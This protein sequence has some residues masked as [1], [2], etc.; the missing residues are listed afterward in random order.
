MRKNILILLLMFLTPVFCQSAQITLNEVVDDSL[1]PTLTMG[2]KDFRLT[3]FENWVRQGLMNSELYGWGNHALAGYESLIG[4]PSVTGY[5]PSRSTAGVWTWVALSGGGD[6]LGVNNLSDLVSAEIARTNLD[7]YGKTDAFAFNMKGDH[8]NLLFDD[9][10]PFNTVVIGGGSGY[11]SQPTYSDEPC[12]TGTFS[13]HTTLG[14][15]HCKDADT[16]DYQVVSG[17]DLV[18]AV[19]DN[20][21]PATT[22]TA[23]DDFNRADSATLGALSGGTYTW[24]DGTGD[25]QIYSNTATG[26]ADQMDV[27]IL[28]P[29]VSINAGTFTANVNAGLSPWGYAGV[30]FGYVDSD[31]YWRAM[32]SPTDPTKRVEVIQVV[33]G[34]DNSIASAASAISVNVDY[35][36]TV[37]VTA[38]TVQVDIDGVGTN[39]LDIT[40]LTIPLGNVGMAS[41]STVSY[42]G[43]LD[44]FNFTVN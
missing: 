18:W 43:Y 36:M 38:S 16:W 7:V 39:I 14:I 26:L 9:G 5:V 11:V 21:T 42:S 12:T 37:R 44:N 29:A 15:V 30:V 24:A 23:L 1:D 8:N 32:I 28:S 40:G 34:S 3:L 31:N 2:G 41:Y 27:S 22:V 6:L 4:N 17:S 33:A 19:W 25:I 13:Y 20:T 10:I 35:I